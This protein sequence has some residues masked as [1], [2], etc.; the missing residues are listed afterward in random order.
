MKLSP[1]VLVVLGV[2]ALV[3][4]A[5]IQ[6]S[7]I[8]LPFVLGFTLAY[9]LDPLADR[10]ERAGL[11]RLVATNV[12]TFAFGFMVLAGLVFGLP[13]LAAELGG[14]VER[15]PVYTQR[16]E[17]WMAGNAILSDYPDAV[18]AGIEAVRG[19]VRGFAGDILLTGLSVLN[20][21]ALII[22]TPVVAVYMLNDWDRMVDQLDR[23]LPKSHAPQVRLLATQ[24][25]E[26]LAGFVR[27]Q[28]TVCFLLAVFYATG[29][30]VVGLDAGIVVGVTAGLTSFIPYVGAVFGVA[31]GLAMGL[32][33]F[34]ADYVMLAQIAGVFVLGQFLEGNVLTPRLVGDRV[35]LH[36]VWII[37]ALLAMGNLFGF[38]GLLLAIPV[39]AAAG[40]LVRYA[41]NIYMREYV[42]GSVEG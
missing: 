9:F 6:L 32:G 14:M 20:V 34:G 24:I 29:L 8:L 1:F 16:L 17:G 23:L 15:I 30:S 2:S 11:P 21:L 7:E 37:F 22:I 27:G 36:P 3:L 4:V 31:L 33:Q 26:I 10:L 18:N 42:E 40:V 5:L 39:A 12:I 13:A 38:I 19:G 35:R 28:I 41:I 25:D